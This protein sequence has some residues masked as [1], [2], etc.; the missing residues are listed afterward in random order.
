MV[1]VQLTLGN[2]S[3][4][5]P[6][7]GHQCSRSHRSSFVAI[8]AWRFKHE[9]SR[10]VTEPYL[11]QFPHQRQ[12]IIVQ[13]VSVIRVFRVLKL[14]VFGKYGYRMGKTITVKCRFI[15]AVDAPSRV[16][17]LRQ[18]SHIRILP[19]HAAICVLCLQQSRAVAGRKTARCSNHSDAVV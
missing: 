12:R 15:A 9:Q 1:T 5:R 16:I 10:D 19:S 17:F 6:C 14:L 4:T 13:Q 7:F 3:H 18:L 8:T 2:S 11:C